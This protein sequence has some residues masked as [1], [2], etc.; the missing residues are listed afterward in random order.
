MKAMHNVYSPASEYTLGISVG[1]DVTV[2]GGTSFAAASL[3]E[4][5]SCAY[6]KVSA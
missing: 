5:G 2:L 4:K 3:A 1:S 6:A